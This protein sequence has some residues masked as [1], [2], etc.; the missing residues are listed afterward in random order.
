MSETQDI[1]EGHFSDELLED[2]K[3]AR[4]RNTSI[5]RL[6]HKVLRDQSCYKTLARHLSLALE[7]GTSALDGLR[8]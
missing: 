6:H 7:F 4:T 1:P 3:Q 2:K 5:L 8:N